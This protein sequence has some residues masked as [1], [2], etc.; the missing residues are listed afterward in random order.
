M[1]NGDG[2]DDDVAVG[3]WMSCGDWRTLHGWQHCGMLYDE[4]LWRMQW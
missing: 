4:G 2:D 3:C 1:D